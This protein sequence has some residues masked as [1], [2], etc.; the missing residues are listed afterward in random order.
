MTYKVD[1]WHDSSPWPYPGHI[2]GQGHSRKM[3]IFR[4]K[5]KVKFCKPD[6]PK[7]GVAD[8]RGWLIKQTCIGNRKEVKKCCIKNVAKVVGAT[9]SESF[10]LLYIHTQFLHN[11][12]NLFGHSYHL[13]TFVGGRDCK[14]WIMT[15]ITVYKQCSCIRRGSRSDESI[16]SR[17]GWQVGD[18]AFWQLFLDICSY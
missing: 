3:F 15:W 13:T 11:M 17:E 12:C 9:S 6:M 14:L 5:V 1:I 16:R 18:T 2:L 7:C 8:R 4:L 10:L